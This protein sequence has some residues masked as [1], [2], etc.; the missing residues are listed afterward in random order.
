MI[1]TLNTLSLGNLVV[2]V[3]SSG[4]ILGRNEEDETMNIVRLIIEFI[5]AVTV[6]AI[7]MFCFAF[8][9]MRKSGVSGFSCLCRLFFFV[10]QCL[11]VYLYVYFS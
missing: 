9:F 4:W 11:Y 6:A 10:I 7:E 8:S 2:K 3:V 1:I 5:V